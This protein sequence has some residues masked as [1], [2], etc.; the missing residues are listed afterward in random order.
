[1]AGVEYVGY[2]IDKNGL[3]CFF[4]KSDIGSIVLWMTKFWST[5]FY[6]IFRGSDEI[7]QL[8]RKT[9]LSSL[10]RHLNEILLGYNRY[11][12]QLRAPRM[13]K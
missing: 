9:N 3:H 7:F 8:S 13:D 6:K 5:F 11:K 2:T 4:I 10:I 12:R 1:M